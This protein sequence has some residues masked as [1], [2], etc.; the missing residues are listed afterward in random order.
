MFILILHADRVP[1]K[2]K[3]IS[4]RHSSALTINHH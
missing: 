1:K 4:R 2:T 3:I